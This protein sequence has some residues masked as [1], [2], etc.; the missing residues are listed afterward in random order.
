MLSDK[1]KMVLA[2]GDTGYNGIICDGSIRSGKSSVVM[3]AFIEW[4]MKH[5][6]GMKFAICGKTQQ[7]AE[8]NVID[9]FI[10]S[11][12]AQN[13]YNMT[14]THNPGKLVVSRK[15]RKNTF[16]IFDGNDK[17]S[18]DKIQGSTLAGVLLDEVVI[19]NK[20]FVEMATGRC[21]VDGAKIWFTCNPDSPQHWFY[22]EYIKRHKELNFLYLHFTMLDNPSLS[23]ERL[24]YYNR[25]YTGN[26][27]KKYIDG[28]WV[29]AEGLVYSIFDKERHMIEPEDIPKQ[30]LTRGRYYV[31]VDYG[32]TN[33]FAA[34]LWVIYHDHA[35]CIDEYYYLLSEHDGRALRNEQLYMNMDKMIKA[36]GVKPESIILDP[37]AASFKTEIDYH[38]EYDWQN[39]YNDVIEGI[40]YTTTLFSRERIHISSKCEG[41]LD[42][43][44]IYSWDMDANHDTPIKEND[45]ACDAMRYF[46]F[47][48]CKDEF[49]E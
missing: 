26:Y 39:A 22:T 20:E 47:T 29:Q 17:K 11:D 19:M 12:F 18:K 35:Y 34:L 15:G 48:I 1:Q 2:F 36:N 37:S 21:S 43:L 49:I 45:H 24:A 32:I 31:S 41:L 7:A 16:H 30:A 4:A 8:R 23:K 3:V 28:L 33:P 38:E 46:A 13:R 9:P 27:R 42:E 40:C 5:F 10:E 14:Y 25:M 6:N 44:S